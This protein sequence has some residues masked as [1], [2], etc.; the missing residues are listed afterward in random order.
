MPLT[1]RPARRCALQKQEAQCWSPTRANLRTF[2][3]VFIAIL[4]LWFH[5]GRCVSVESFERAIPNLYSCQTNRCGWR[6]G[7]LDG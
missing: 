4:D 2:N 5:C 3:T 7:P 1:Q 6:D